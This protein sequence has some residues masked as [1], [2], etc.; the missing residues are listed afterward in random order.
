MDA[1]AYVYPWDVAGDPAAA[2]LTASLGL[3]HV[4]LAAVYHATRALTPRHPAHRVVVAERTAAYLPLAAAPWA[5][6]GLRPEEQNWIPGTDSFGEAAAALAAAGLPVHAWVVVDHVDSFFGPHVENAY[7]DIYPWSLCPAQ[8]AVRDYAVNLAAEV[9][10]RP[11]VA[12]VEFE[13]AGWYGFDHLHEH[14]KVAG[15]ALGM[16]EQFL[17]SLCFCSACL[18]EYAV[19]DIDADEL[20]RTVREVLDRKFRGTL[21]VPLPDHEV[22]AIQRALGDLADPVLTMRARVGDRLRAAMVE[23]VRAHRPVGFPVVFHGNPLAH[24]ST[25]FTGLGPRSL[26]KDTDGVVVN[27][28]DGSPDPVSAVTAAGVP[29]Y[30]GVLAVQGMGARR[31]RAEAVVKDLAA[32][33]AAGIRIYHAGLA[34]PGDL[35]FVRELAAVARAEP[36]GTTPAPGSEH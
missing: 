1:A 3:D 33:G 6:T 7:G 9:S 5:P 22:F 21:G 24:R 25:A 11:D 2:E 26:P 16:A 10:S 8:Q 27:C 14:D 30:A 31:E 36:S 32:A 19:S 17:F 12:G 34:G 23:E 29:A 28:W 20:R 4:T 18:E 13:A 15:V 35:D